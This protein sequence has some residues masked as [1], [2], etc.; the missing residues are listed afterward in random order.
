VPVHVTRTAE[1]ALAIPEPPPVLPERQPAGPAFAR[2]GL[3]IAAATAAY[4]VTPLLTDND[5]P[6]V[7][8]TGLFLTAGGVGFWE[9]RPGKPLPDNV[10]ANE[11]A[12]AAWRARVAKIEQEN[13]RRAV[14]G[15]V[16]VEVGG[17]RVAQR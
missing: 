11:T 1:N 17:V 10:V 8:A 5:A 4:F 7:L 3:G 6:R 9:A 15:T 12:R 2:L 16:H 14:G 13:R